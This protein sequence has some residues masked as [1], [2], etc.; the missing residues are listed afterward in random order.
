MKYLLGV[1]LNTKNQQRRYSTFDSVTRTVRTVSEGQ[2][3]EELTGFK[4]LKVS[5][6]SKRVSGNGYTFELSESVDGVEQ[7]KTYTLVYYNSFVGVDVYGL[8]D[9]NG[10]L[11]WVTKDCV[12]RLKTDNA[13]NCLRLRK[14]LIEGTIDIKEHVSMQEIK[15]T[16]TNVLSSVSQ[17]KVSVAAADSSKSK[18]NMDYSNVVVRPDSVEKKQ[19]S[20][21]QRTDSVNKNQSIEIDNHVIESQEELRELAMARAKKFMEENYGKTT[22]ERIANSNDIWAVMQ[23]DIDRK[24]YKECKINKEDVLEVYLRMQKISNTFKLTDEELKEYYF[25]LDDIT[26]NDSGVV[27]Y[28]GIG[29]MRPKKESKRFA[30]V[31]L[32]HSGTTHMNQVRMLTEYGYNNATYI[33]LELLKRKIKEER[34]IRTT[35]YYDIFEEVK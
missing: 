28:A 33:Q 25:N 27:N 35:R 29:R 10:K 9:L 3:I 31:F 17:N 1:N 7:R 18:H 8:V 11:N 21:V 23:S 2:L 16:V 30:W 6:S 22:D 19:S 20:V 13:V 32:I 5:K 15:N 26:E 14:G 24:E 12:I 4:G 34:R